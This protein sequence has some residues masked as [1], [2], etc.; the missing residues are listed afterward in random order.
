MNK[1]VLGIGIALMVVIIAGVLIWKNQCDE[2]IEQ[3]LVD[4]NQNQVEIK[5]SNSGWKTYDSE[6]YEFEIKYPP[7]L[8]ANCN[9]NVFVKIEGMQESEV[10]ACFNFED[11]YYFVVRVYDN[12]ELKT[13]RAWLDDKYDAYSGGW[14]WDFDE[15]NLLS[16][17]KAYFAKRD[18]H[19]TGFYVEYFIVSEKDKIYSVRVDMSSFDK[20][21]LDK[22]IEVIRGVMKTFTLK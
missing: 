17:K 9:E 22:K 14:S 18:E 2:K 5:E 10:G 3:Q 16:G 11:S 6:E 12:N 20:D 7:S 4:K 8:T 1:K 19:D 15:T 21:D 13:P